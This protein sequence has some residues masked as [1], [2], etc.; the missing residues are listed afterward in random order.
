MRCRTATVD[1]DAFVRARQTIKADAASLSADR[2]RYGQFVSPGFGIWLDYDWQKKGWKPAEP[3][4]NHFSPERLE[5]A[6]AL[7]SSNPTNMSGSTRKSR[8]GGRRTGRSIF[9]LR[10]RRD[11]SPRPPCARWCFCSSSIFHR[12]RAGV[13]VFLDVDSCPVGGLLTSPSE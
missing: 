2:S 9:R 6:F 7:Q 5:R 12:E 1:A 10:L 8:G 11:N 4:S 3:E 13:R